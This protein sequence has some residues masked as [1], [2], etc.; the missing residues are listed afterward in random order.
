P[1]DFTSAAAIHGQTELLNSKT[2]LHSWTSVEETAFNR[3]FDEYAAVCGLTFQLASS[4]ATA[5]IDLWL[6]PRIRENAN[7]LGVFEVP[8]QR[9]D[10]QE[11][12]FFNDT[13]P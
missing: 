11:W 12:G 7:L 1:A 3:A 4:A 13:A 9:Q 2:T 5:N 10:G 6:I 8:S